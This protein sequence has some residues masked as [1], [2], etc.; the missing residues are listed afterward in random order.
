MALLGGAIGARSATEIISVALFM[1]AGFLSVL[2]HELG[3]A[4]TAR[5]FG[6]RSEI[7][8]HAFGG[9]AVF[10]GPT[11]SRK[12]SLWITAAGP[13]LQ[14][15]LAAA[16]G[17]LR[18]F[19]EDSYWDLN[20]Y[21]LHFLHWLYGISIFWALLNLL[22][23]HPLDGGQIL[24]FILGPARLRITLW[25]TMATA[26]VAGSLFYFHYDHLLFPVFVGIFAW[27]AW[28]RLQQLSVP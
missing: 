17:S 3:H 28:K 7:I 20:P 15:A 22:P 12:Q 4:A 13:L 5:R 18:L 21:F 11:M 19:L 26:I 8:L 27:Q 16:I 24:H 6:A 23:I 25:V 2:V 10:N 1:T 9:V 14:L